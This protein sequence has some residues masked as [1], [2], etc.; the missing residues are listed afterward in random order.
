MGDPGRLRQVL[1]NLIGNALKFT[2]GGSVVVRIA[3]IPKAPGSSQVTFSI[4]DTGMG[5]PPEIQDRLFQPFSQADGSFARRHGGTGLGLAICRRLV[6]LMGGEIGLRSEL[7]RG[8]EFHFTLP[9]RHD[10]EAPVPH[11]AEFRDHR[12]LLLGAPNTALSQLNHLLI[13]HGLSVKVATSLEEADLIGSQASAAGEVFDAVI[14]MPAAVTKEP[15]DL[16]ADLRGTPRIWFSYPGQRAQCQQVNPGS[17]S[18]FLH[19]PL[20]EAQ[21]RSTL[22]KV[23]GIALAEAA[24]HP[25]PAPTHALTAGS[26]GYLLLVED[27]LINQRVA[28]SLLGKAGYRMDTA[29]T[30]IEALLAMSSQAYDLVIMDCH[31]PE[32][33]GFEATRQWRRK[34]SPDRRL[35][36]IALT[37]NTMAGDRET[38]LAAGMDDYIGKPIRRDEMLATVAKWMVERATPK[39]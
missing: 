5:I 29:K 31:M 11:S 28:G 23:F 2:E 9:Y 24:N 20:K 18:A 17:I 27:N 26:R 1:M 13:Q 7:D 14:E 33:D 4:T 39:G 35:P 15:L 16:G 3:S 6:I 22:R 34:E 12:I 10:P 19:R 8:S 32:M 37:A 36:I 38:C 30:G 25:Q 21:L